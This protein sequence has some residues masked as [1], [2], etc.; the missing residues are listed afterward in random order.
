M[1]DPLYDAIPRFTRDTGI[2][3]EIVVRLP[4]PELNAWVASNFASGNPGVDVLSTHTKY[5]PSQAQWLEPLDD[6]VTPEHEADLLPK[7]PESRPGKR[8]PA[9]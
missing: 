3:V 5:A 2:P 8:N 9:R 4:H 7:R 1:Y 6:V